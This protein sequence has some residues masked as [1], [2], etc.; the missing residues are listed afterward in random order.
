MRK[1]THLGRRNFLKTSVFGMFGAGMATKTGWAQE[2]EGTQEQSKEIK[3]KTQPK[4]KGYRILGRTGFKVS[5]LAI[6]YIQDEGLMSAML[7]AGANYID[8]AESYPGAHSTISKVI[9][10]RDRKSLFITTKMLMEGDTSKKGL[11]KRVQKALQELDT[12]YVDCIMMHMPDKIEMLKNEA[13]HAAMQELKS[14]GRIRFV[15][16]THH[17]SFW[18]RGPEET[19]DKILLAAADDGRFDVFLF[20]YNFLKM[21]QSEKVLEACKEKNIGTVLMKSTPVFKY[22]VIKSRLEKLEKEGK[23]I[24][25]LYKEGLKRFKDKFDKAEQFIKKYDLQNPDE[26]RGAAIRFVLNNPLVNTV[27]CSINTYDEMERVLPLSG[28]KLS[29]RDKAKLAAYKESCGELYCRHACGL[30]EPRCPQGVPVNT[31]MRYFHYFAAQGR[32]KEAMLQYAAIPGARADSCHECPG[33]CE[34]ACHYNVPIQGML[35]LAH[36]QLLMA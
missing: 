6:G 35:L 20:A 3:D 34:K 28:S 36:N 15:G 22:Y 25:P 29:G 19:M 9:K 33:Y 24:H 30:C 11:I 5:D 10:G 18:L 27:C 17:G 4:I 23:D 13:F 1:K 14:E 2:K 31:I 32:E 12:E 26:I 8:T 21:D 7:D 16:V